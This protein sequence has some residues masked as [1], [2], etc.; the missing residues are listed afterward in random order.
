MIKRVLLCVPPFP[1]QY[2]TPTHPHTGIGYLSESLKTNGIETSVIDLR[3]SSRDQL[4][5][6][7]QD[8]RPDLLG[9]TMMTY[10]HNLA[11]EVVA[12]L[13]QYNIPIAIGGPHVSTTSQTAIDEC[14]ADFGFLME[15]ERSL[16]QFCKGVDYASIPGFIYQRDGRYV[17][18]PP[19]VID[20]LDSLP[21]P[22]YEDLDLTA[23]GR[24]RIPIFTSRGCPCLCTF[25]PIVTVMGRKYRLRSAEHVF[26]ELAYWYGKG[27]RD[28][29]FQDDNF[30]VN[31]SRVHT[32]CAKIREAGFNDLLI[33]CG[34]GIRADTATLDLLQA[35]RGVGFRATAFGV[36]SATPEVLKTVR[37][38]ETI[39]QIDQGVRN[40]L[41]AGIEVSLFFI[42]GLPG[43]TLKTFDNS[44]KFALKYPVTTASFYNLIPFP[45]TELFDWVRKNNYFLIEPKKY[46]NS[47][48]HHEFQPLFETPDFPAS[49]RKKALKAGYRASQTIK[50]R[51]FE[52]KLGGRWWTRI[53]SWLIYGR[54]F[55]R[56]FFAV[57]RIGWIKRIINRILLRARIRINL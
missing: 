1:N 24:A 25:C 41:A 57:I 40:A 55:N 51:D 11:Y 46:L 10:H 16:V 13:K 45:G 22:K 34:N 47:I 6:R 5:K 31:K 18:N 15:G 4:H 50:R 35:M 32:L 12:D 3:L 48:A 52:R 19:R 53:A 23:Y 17:I 38:G 54:L 39:E 56:L 42:V 36:E 26:A 43:E 44:L 7:V 2:G 8:F 29:D 49:D 20:D 28:F 21:F 14:K 27:Y 37:K 30:T 9:V 33:Q